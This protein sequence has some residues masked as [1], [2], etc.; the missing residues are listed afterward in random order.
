M[1]DHASHRV[2]M[3]V[4]RGATRESFSLPPGAN[5]TLRE[6]F[7]STDL[8]SYATAIWETPHRSVRFLLELPVTRR[9]LA[10]DL[11]LAD[12]AGAPVTL[13]EGEA[14]ALPHRLTA[15]ELEVLTLVAAGLSNP[16]IAE[17]L[18]TSPRTVSTQA[19]TILKKL[20]ASSRT[21]AGV[22]AVQRG[23]VKLPPP[24]SPD[25]I[26]PLAIGELA[27]AASAPWTGA[28]A[29]A[30]ERDAVRLGLAYARSGPGHSD[31]LLAT[32]GAL[33]A[34]DELN[35]RGGVRGRRIEPVPVDADIYSA[36]GIR[37][38]FRQ[39]RERDVQG[40]LMNYVFDERAA[41]ESAAEL[42]I[43]VL[44][45][46]TSSRHVAML[47]ADPSRYRTLFQCAPPES[48]YGPGVARFLEL[49]SPLLVER[50]MEQTIRFVETTLDSGQI[51]NAATQ[52]LLA[53]AGW[54]V[55][56][57]DSFD[58]TSPDLDAISHALTESLVA[59]P[60]AVLVITEFQPSAL[61][62]LLRRIHAAEIP[63]IIYT[64]YTPSMPDFAA[65]LGDAA[66]GIVWATVSGTYG[67]VVGEAFARDFAAA[68]GE[69]PGY[70]QAGLGYDL[71]HILIT[72][73]QHTA[74]PSDVDGTLAALRATRYRGV[75][76]SY[77]FGT[78]GQSAVA[79]PEETSDPS[80]GNAHLLFQIQ[81]GMHVRLGP[82]PYGDG[83]F[84]WPPR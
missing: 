73:W 23:W 68:Y 48:N 41:F 64:I 51:A 11:T 40:I 42:E 58:P 15:R 49:L 1:R 47:T 69:E 59:D 66:E 63:S 9:W 33:L 13:V 70:S 25:A 38:T 55:T 26:A 17:H 45:T 34:I 37:D 61:S 29:P 74:D 14:I 4:P 16:A 28:P 78:D 31:G 57:I 2:R 24:V 21:A 12:S 18:F 75:N 19:E 43:P 36:A 20:G 56:E 32:R 80:L 52:D 72:A 30:P 54:S 84:R 46:M 39:L 3:L 50:G 81:D 44:H 76:G 5:Q 67:D 35:R 83:E 6:A 22:L 60:P 53:A 79:Y 82:A 65:A 10:V 77:T 27:Q 7:G 71:A 8:L 62:Q